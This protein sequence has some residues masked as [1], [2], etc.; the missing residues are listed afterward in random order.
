MYLASRSATGALLRIFRF[1]RHCIPGTMIKVRL[2]QH[3]YRDTLFGYKYVL[4]ICHMHRRKN[5][6]LGL[7]RF[8]NLKT[9]VSHFVTPPIEA[10]NNWA[11]YE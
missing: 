7:R 2:V 4:L 8:A 10:R 3:Q 6:C 11:K 1:R 9:E 5:R